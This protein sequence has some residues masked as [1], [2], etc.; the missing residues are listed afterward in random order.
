VHTKKCFNDFTFTKP[1]KVNRHNFVFLEHCTFLK[2]CD[3]SF[4]LQDVATMLSYKQTKMC[5]L[6]IEES[7]FAAFSSKTFRREF[8][9]EY[10]CAEASQK[11]KG[12]NKFSRFSMVDL[13]L[14]YFDVIERNI[15][16][17][18]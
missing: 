5:R 9:K 13:V 7:L 1:Q 16:T 8:N 12:I 2:C 18:K 6:Q 17:V 4:N 11:E 15:K 14:H 3:T 10:V